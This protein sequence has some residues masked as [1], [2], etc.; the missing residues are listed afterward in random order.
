MVWVITSKRKS[1]LMV[2]R[3]TRKLMLWYLED[4]IKPCYGILATSKSMLK[5]IQAIRKSIS[6]LKAPIFWK[7]VI[8]AKVLD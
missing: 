8:L 1:K 3:T 6:L 7:I 4:Q 5:V 2:F